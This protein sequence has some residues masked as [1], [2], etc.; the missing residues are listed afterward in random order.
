MAE[1]IS[2]FEEYY[3]QRTSKDRTIKLIV[4]RQTR[5]SYLNMVNKIYV[6]MIKYRNDKKYGTNIFNRKIKREIKSIIDDF[7]SKLNKNLL[8]KCILLANYSIRSE[9]KDARSINLK[10]SVDP[11]GYA[12]T[13]YLYIEDI[14]GYILT[15]RDRMLNQIWSSIR[16][17]CIKIQR[18][19]K[20][21]NISRNKAR[22]ICV[23]SNHTD[24]MFVFE[25]KLNRK[26]DAGGYFEMLARSTMSS[27]E[28][29]SYIYAMITDGFDTAKILE[30]AGENKC[31]KY[32]G[33]LI[34]I[35]GKN[36]N[37]PSIYEISDGGKI[38]HPNCSHLISVIEEQD[39]LNR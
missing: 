11:N 5:E 1:K 35:S 30:C 6:A 23:S 15:Q 33:T 37:L 25:D 7:V 19:M 12:D 17:D 29:D 26:R 32:D 31:S 3:L 2:G 36:K 9:K 10:S 21:E 24:I 28:L 27:V 14:N 16:S 8:K 39:D 4:L 34:S 20:Y 13:V 18:L 38:W 22:E